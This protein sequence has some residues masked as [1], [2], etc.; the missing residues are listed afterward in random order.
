M[1]P[2]L[3]PHHRGAHGSWNNNIGDSGPNR[4]TVGCTGRR[5]GFAGRFRLQDD[6]S[7]YIANEVACD[8]NAGFVAA[9]G[10]MARDYGG[11]PPPA[12]EFPAGDSYGR[13]M[14]VEASI[15]ETGDDHVRLRCMLNNCSA[16]PARWSDTLSYR[17]STSPN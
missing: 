15:I 8:Y 17:T 7:D 2:P 16:W 10:R 12:V 13:E 14:Y 5:T 11:S 9:L 3:A 1:N 6:R 4:H